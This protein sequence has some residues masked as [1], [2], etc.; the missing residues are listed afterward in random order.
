MELSAILNSHKAEVPSNLRNIRFVESLEAID[1]VRTRCLTDSNCSSPIEDPLFEHMTTLESL[2]DQGNFK[3]VLVQIKT[4]HQNSYLE[5]LI[6]AFNKKPS[7]QIFLLIGIL[8]PSLEL[9]EDLFLPQEIELKPTPVYAWL[10]LIS[11]DQCRYLEQFIRF[12]GDCYSEVSGKA[13]NP[14]FKYCLKPRYLQDESSELKNIQDEELRKKLE[15]SR[16]ALLLQAYHLDKLDRVDLGWPKIMEVFTCHQA[17]RLK[18]KALSQGISYELEDAFKFHYHL[19]KLF[20]YFNENKIAK[21]KLSFFSDHPDQLFQAQHLQ[22][23]AVFCKNHPRYP[24][25]SALREIFEEGFIDYFCQLSISESQRSFYDSESLLTRFVESFGGLIQKAGNLNHEE[26]LLFKNVQEQV[27]YKIAL[28]ML[29]RV[30]SNDYLK[31]RFLVKECL[32]EDSHSIQ[33]PEREIAQFYRSVVLDICDQYQKIIK[34]V[35]SK[36]F[37]LF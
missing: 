16:D 21:E 2:L 36:V 26:S 7:L 22:G 4:F 10:E 17:L 6:L 29:G 9:L 37:P 27:F 13:L 31:N 18:K 25:M 30:S 11:Q 3:I 23:L 14:F 8:H 24:Q 15:I 20:I 34:L 28:D 5:N 35:K 19:S 1:S 32:R 12:Y 33:F